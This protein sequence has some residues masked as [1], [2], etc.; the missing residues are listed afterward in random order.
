ML[1]PLTK[2]LF[3]SRNN[4]EIKVIDALRVAGYSTS[5]SRARGWLEID[6]VDYEINEI[7]QSLV[8]NKDIFAFSVHFYMSLI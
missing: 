5:D 3:I 4:V 8:P 7:F 2:R 1:N 6:S